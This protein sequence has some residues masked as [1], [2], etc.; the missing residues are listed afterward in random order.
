MSITITL[1]AILFGA[2][3]PFLWAALSTFTSKEV[4]TNNGF[5]FYFG[6]ALFVSISVITVGMYWDLLGLPSQ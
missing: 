3:V 4:D 6:F 2:W 5:T 1:Y